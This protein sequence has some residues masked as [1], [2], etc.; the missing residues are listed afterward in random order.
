M[1]D[2]RHA[3]RFALAGLVGAGTA[4]R[5][6]T[7]APSA[8]E[9]LNQPG[10]EAARLA[11]R[12]GRWLVTETAW[13]GPDAAP[14]TTTGLIADRV[15]IGTLL[16]ETIRPSGEPGARTPSRTDLL[17]FNRL[18]GRWDYVSFDTRGP[19][20]IMVAWSRGRGENDTVAFD[21]LPFAIPRPGP[22]AVGQFL[23]LDQVIR[24]VDDDHDVKE[25]FLT[26]AD[27]SGTRWLGHRY[28]YAR[29]GGRS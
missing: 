29:V 8:G 1:L 10:P 13:D 9:R 6:A 28:G 23:R 7:A 18:E 27:G 16:Q 3:L 5:A 11:A 20:G 26:F 14:A 2:R 17:S 15:M 24:F 25:Q 4:G 12:T 22:D 21:F 19:D